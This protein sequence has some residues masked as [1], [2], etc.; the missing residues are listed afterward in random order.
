MKLQVSAP[1]SYLVERY[2]EEIA[3]TYDVPWRSNII[4]H[5]EEEDLLQDD[6]LIDTDDDNSSGGGGGGG[7]KEAL[8][9]LQNPIAS[10]DLPEIPSNSPLKKTNTPPADDPNDFDALARR[11]DALKRK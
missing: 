6:T 9:P 11:L 3:R 8:P 4:D 1:D 10:I 2:L 5:E 7:Q